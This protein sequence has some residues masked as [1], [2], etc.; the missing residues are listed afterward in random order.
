MV[1]NA[2]LTS[3]SFF[4]FF[5]IMLKNTSTCFPIFCLGPHMWHIEVPRLGVKLEPQL[6][7]YTTTTA[8]WDP[9]RVCNLH[10]SSQQA[11]SLNHWARPGIE[12]ASSCIL[13]RFITAEPQW[14]L[15]FLM[16]SDCTKFPFIWTP[17]FLHLYCSPLFFHNDGN[18]MIDHDHM[19]HYAQYLISQ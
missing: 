15:R 2:F 12:P 4:Q 7:A 19:N 5:P 14:E 13:V 6:L 10:H 16:S 17:S 1:E 3:L 8:S 18:K 9:S 11:R